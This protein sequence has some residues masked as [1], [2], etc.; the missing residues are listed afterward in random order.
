MKVVTHTRSPLQGFDTALSASFRSRST[1]RTSRQTRRRCAERSEFRQRCSCPPR[2]CVCRQSSPRVW[3]RRPA[4]CSRRARRRCRRRPEIAAFRAY[5]R[6]ET[7]Q[8]RF[9]ETSR[10]FHE[11]LRNISTSQWLTLEI[12]KFSHDKE[13]EEINRKQA[14]VQLSTLAAFAVEDEAEVSP[15]WSSPETATPSRSAP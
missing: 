10:K 14:D 2:A 9:S 11:L 3:G 8:K 13:T 12:L 15:E 5:A 1:T 4:V 6:S 7:F